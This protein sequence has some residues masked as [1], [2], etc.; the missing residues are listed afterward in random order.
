MLVSD[1]GVVLPMV[2]SEAERSPELV[3]THY[4]AAGHTAQQV[5]FVVAMYEPEGNAAY[6]SNLIPIAEVSVSA[7][8]MIGGGLLLVC[9]AATALRQRSPLADSAA[10]PQR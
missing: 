10:D 9:A 2:L 5:E 3:R 1:Y 7:M 6:R 4:L 8:S